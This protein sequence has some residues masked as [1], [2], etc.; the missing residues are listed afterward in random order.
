MESTEQPGVPTEVLIADG[1]T[2]LSRHGL[3]DRDWQKALVILL[4]L[5]AAVACSRAP[6]R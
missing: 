4:S 3:L 5:L 6:R 1:A 2:S